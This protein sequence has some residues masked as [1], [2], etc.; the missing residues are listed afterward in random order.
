[1]SA[2]NKINTN[3]QS[4]TVLSS[5]VG[6]LSMKNSVWWCSRAFVT[7]SDWQMTGLLKS[8]INH[9]EIYFHPETTNYLLSLQTVNPLLVAQCWEKNTGRNACDAYKSNCCIPQSQ[10]KCWL[11]FH[12]NFL[13]CPCQNPQSSLAR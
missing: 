12:I 11:S 6:E 1:M 3:V 7:L 5:G 9:D 4:T 2:E 10:F 8:E 13:L